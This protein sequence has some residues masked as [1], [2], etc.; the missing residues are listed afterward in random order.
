MAED[1]IRSLSYCVGAVCLGAA[2]IVLFAIDS[3]IHWLKRGK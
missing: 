2:G 3:I 1:V